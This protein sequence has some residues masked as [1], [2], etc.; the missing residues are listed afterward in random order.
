MGMG[1]SYCRVELGPGLG[2]ELLG[3]LLY[4][5]A[6]TLDLGRGLVEV[7]CDD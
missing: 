1:D 2:A 7:A 6:I 3:L 5:L 4:L